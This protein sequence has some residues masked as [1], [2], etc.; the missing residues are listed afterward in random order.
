LTQ[1]RRNGAI[2][3]SG[4]KSSWA[5]SAQAAF[6]EAISFAKGCGKAIAALVTNIKP[7]K[8]KVIAGYFIL[9]PIEIA[10]YRYG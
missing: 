1:S 5:I 6:K 3:L 4:N 7:E 9:C 8:I 10:L 2:S